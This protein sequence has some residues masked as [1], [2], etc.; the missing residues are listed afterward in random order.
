MDISMWNHFKTITPRTNN[1]LEGY[2]NALNHLYVDQDI[3][4]YTGS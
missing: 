4:T 2:N 1:N 3:Q